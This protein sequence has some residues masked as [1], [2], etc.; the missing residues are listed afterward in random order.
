MHLATR[1]NTSDFGRFFDDFFAPRR[2]AG[3]PDQS[4][5]SPQVDIES[6]DDHYVI[7][8]DFP[9]VNKADIQVSLENGIL[10]LEAQRNDEQSE[11]KSGK[12]LRKERRFGKFTRSFHVPRNIAAEEVKGSF[13][14]GVLTLTIPKES[15]RAQDEQRV[16]ID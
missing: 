15:Q 5:Y 6:K 3:S 14:N 2:S 8:A 1:D 9:G 11:E 16:T 13:E 7:H 12:V 4:F 10:T